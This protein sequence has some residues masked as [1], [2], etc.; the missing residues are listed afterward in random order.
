M[1]K[2]DKI[3][4]WIATIWLAL[5][6]TSTGIVQLTRMQEEVDKMAQLGYAA[7]FL[8]ILG[9]WKIL[10]VVAVL[11]P[12]FPLLKEWAYAGFFFA[13]S[14]AIFSHVAVGDDAIEY[15]GPALLLIL[16]AVSWY[17]RPAERKIIS[18]NTVN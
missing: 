7:Y 11:A 4:Y 17:F 18:V 3:I 6:M 13:M 5:G 1:K 12:K 9:I 2:R 8:T 16:T 14:G 10:G 15:F